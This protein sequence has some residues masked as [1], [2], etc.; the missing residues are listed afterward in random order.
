M[1]GYGVISILLVFGSSW[2]FTRAAPSKSSQSLR[3]SF[4]ASNASLFDMLN[5]SEVDFSKIYF[6]FIDNASRLEFRKYY[7]QMDKSDQKSLLSLKHPQVYEILP[8]RK[9][10]FYQ[11]VEKSP[12]SNPMYHF[13]KAE[14]KIRRKV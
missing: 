1:A 11:M 4:M 9:V 3:Q 12:G 8:G 2:I 14:E 5:I 6:P 7:V 10:D 13:Q